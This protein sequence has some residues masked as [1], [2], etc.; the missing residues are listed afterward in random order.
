MTR[1]SNI[2]I[3]AILTIIII[4]IIIIIIVEIIGRS[5][6]HQQCAMVM[7]RCAFPPCP[8]RVGHPSNS[9]ASSLRRGG[10]GQGY[11]GGSFYIAILSDIFVDLR[12]RRHDGC[13]MNTHTP[14]IHTTRAKH[15]HRTRCAFTAPTSE[16]ARVPA[17]GSC[18]RFPLG[19]R[20]FFP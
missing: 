14:R 20:L 7:P 12:R 2:I 11:Q 17:N 5:Q 4:I 10:E 15:L 18:L 19:S 8:A 16:Q 1:P 3:T 6:T 9:S 13:G